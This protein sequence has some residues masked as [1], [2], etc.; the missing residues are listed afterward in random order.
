[1]SKRIEVKTRIQVITDNK[2]YTI[3]LCRVTQNITSRKEASFMNFDHLL[4]ALCLVQIKSCNQYFQYFL[5]SWTNFID[6]VP[7]YRRIAEMIPLHILRSHI[8]EKPS[9]LSK[10]GLFLTKVTKVTVARSTLPKRIA[11]VW[12]KSDEVTPRKGSTVMSIC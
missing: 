5:W 2:V 8:F 11:L 3:G 6:N 7:S 4:Q 12:L 1:M 9:Y 10:S